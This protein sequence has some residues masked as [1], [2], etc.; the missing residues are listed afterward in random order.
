VSLDD[1]F[2][3]IEGEPGWVVD[4]DARTAT[5]PAGIPVIFSGDAHDARAVEGFYLTAVKNG[6]P[7]AP[8]FPV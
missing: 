8:Q 2:D 4:R 1:L 6:L 3:Y 7:E 5:S